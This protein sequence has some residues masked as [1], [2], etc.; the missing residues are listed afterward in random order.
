MGGLKL[1]LILNECAG[2]AS[3]RERD[4]Q[5]PGIPPFL[6]T[7]RVALGVGRL[8]RVAERSTRQQRAVFLYFT[9]CHLP[10]V[11]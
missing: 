1:G 5:P 11:Q 9:L 10:R 4:R 6:G 3:F 2:Y 7:L 8:A